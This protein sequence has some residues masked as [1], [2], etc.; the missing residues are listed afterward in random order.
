MYTEY[1]LT[2]Q[3]CNTVEDSYFLKYIKRRLVILGHELKMSPKKQKIKSIKLLIKLP[4]T[5]INII[6]ELCNKTLFNR[7]NNRTRACEIYFCNNKLISTLYPGTI[8]DSTIACE[9]IFYKIDNIYGPISIKNIS[10]KRFWEILFN[11]AIQQL[12]LLFPLQEHENNENI[13]MLLNSFYNMVSLKTCESISIVTE[14]HLKHERDDED[15]P[16]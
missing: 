7:H 2:Y 11:K 12:M 1:K 10:R 4:I 9:I 3:M 8:N 5:D 6:D 16:F 15:L 13:N 14:Y